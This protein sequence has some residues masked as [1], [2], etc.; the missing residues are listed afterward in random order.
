MLPPASDP[1]FSDAFCNLMINNAKH[2]PPTLGS[3]TVYDEQIS[4]H[5]KVRV[6]Q[7]SDPKSRDKALPLCLFIH[8]GGWVT[9]SLDTEDHFCRDI[10]GRADVVVVSVLYRKFPAVKFPQNTEDCV[11]GVLWAYKHATTLGADPKRFLM[12]GG[13]AGG[14]LAVA[15]THF[16]IEFHPTVPP[17]AGLL[18][19]NSAHIHPEG[20]PKGYEHLYT[21]Y[22]ENAGPIPFV[23]DEMSRGGFHIMDGEAPYDDKRKHW[24]PV[25]MGVEGVKGFPRTWL[26]NS[27]KECFRDDGRVLE[28]LLKESGV[29]VKREL[30]E[31]MPH[32]YF[33]FP[34]GGEVVEDFR[35]RTLRGIRWCLES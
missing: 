7:P 11:E 5:V 22:T 19:I 28:A 8:G 29:P 26:L 25:S 30:V 13:S 17:L 2:F 23:T 12:M 4:E 14:G 24:V 9:G 32:Y 15:A 10:S 31:G 33:A 18:P 27:G 20:C 34:L 6:Y 35:Q 16:L 21:A 1:G 3:V